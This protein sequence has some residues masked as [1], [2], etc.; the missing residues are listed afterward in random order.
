M[1]GAHQ[2]VQPTGASRS[3]QKQIE[4]QRRLAPVADLYVPPPPEIS[5]LK[6]Q[7]SSFTPAFP[8]STFYSVNGFLLSTFRFQLLF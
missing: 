8:L 4:R 6:F 2:T 7:F 5:E 3:A 1:S